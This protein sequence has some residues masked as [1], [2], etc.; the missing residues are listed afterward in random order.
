MA[1]SLL[2]EHE[3]AMRSHGQLIR[4]DSGIPFPIRRGST[5]MEII[6]AMFLLATLAVVSGQIV[7]S[8]VQTRLEQRK[9]A[10]ALL[11]AGNVM[12]E[13]FLL[14]WTELE[15]APSREWPCSAA[16]KQVLRNPRVLLLTQLTQDENTRRLVVTVEWSNGRDQAPQHIQLVAFRHRSQG[17]GETLP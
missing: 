15:G 17:T 2:I 1:A 9:R 11:E 8:V 12:E 16:A 13:V 3:Q 14:P 6:I 5:A 10:Y 7:I 4:R